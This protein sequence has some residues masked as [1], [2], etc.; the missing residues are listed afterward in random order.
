M[1]IYA[2]N[3]SKNRQIEFLIS[4]VKQYDIKGRKYYI[5]SAYVMSD[6]QKKR[7]NVRSLC[8]SF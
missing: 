1:R 2:K 7:N 6:E 4:E 5:Q 3:W 8:F